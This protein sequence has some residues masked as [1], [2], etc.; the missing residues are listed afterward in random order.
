MKVS[1][2]TKPLHAADG[3]VL[4]VGAYA[5][6]KRLPEPL[7]HLDR[8][9]GGQMAEVLK[10]EQFQGKTGQLSHFYTA[11]RVPA[12]RVMVV[13]LGARGQVTAETVRRAAAAGVRRAR[14]LGARVVSIDVLGDPLPLGQRARAVVGGAILGTYTFERYRKEKTDKVVEEL[15]LVDPDARRAEALNEAIRI[16]QRFAEATS[17]AR[18]LINAPANEVNPTYLA[19]TAAEIAR[20]GKLKLRVYERAECEKMGMGAYLGVALGSDSPPKFIHLTYHPPGRARRRVAIIGKGITFDSGGLDLKPADGMLRMKNDMSGAAAVLA[21][22]RTL[23]ALKPP[24]EVHAIIAATENM[25]SGKAQRPGD[26]VRA[27]NG[28]TIEIGNTDAEGRLTL[29]DALCYAVT[30]V[31]PD[32]MIDVATLTGA[33][34]VALGSLCAGLLT[35]DQPLADRVKAAADLVGERVWQLPM[36]DEYKEGLKSDVAD[37]NNVGPRGGGAIN[38]G[39]FMKEFVGDIPWVHLDIAGPAFSDKDLPLCPKGGTGFGVRTLLAYLTDL[40]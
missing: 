17:F 34:V 21:V 12:K 40:K 37:I 3:D 14:D 22:M 11:G 6:D 39:I 26:I 30:R 2:L 31:K 36:I 15:R 16:G 38:A 32:E 7:A 5:E 8:T 1:L 18:D 10:E 9:L 27:M 29:A 23:P 13:G 33:C 25:V 20:E 28:V 4:I 35:N 19:K 24:L